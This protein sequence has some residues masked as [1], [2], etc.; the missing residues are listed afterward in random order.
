MSQTALSFAIKFALLLRLLPLSKLIFSCTVAMFFARLCSVVASC[1][2]R[3][4]K[5]AG[6]SPLA[7]GLSHNWWPFG[8]D[9]PQ[10]GCKSKCGTKRAAYPVGRSANLILTASWWQKDW[11]LE[12]SGPVQSFDVI[13]ADVA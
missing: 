10:A 12:P 4:H 9:L 11:L 3:K 5:L 7:D 8:G 13:M 1:R 2:G 6:R